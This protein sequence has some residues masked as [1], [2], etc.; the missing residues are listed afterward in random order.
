[1]KTV[2]EEKTNV[3]VFETQL[4]DS[5][6]TTRRGEMSKSAERMITA[7]LLVFF[8]VVLGLTAYLFMTRLFL[9]VEILLVI[10]VIS[11]L[12]ALAILIL[13]FSGLYK[14]VRISNPA[15]IQATDIAAVFGLIGIFSCLAP[16]VYGVFSIPDFMI[17]LQNFM[18]NQQETAG[19]MLKILQSLDKRI[20]SSA[21]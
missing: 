8:L 20:P 6:K 18:S 1:M 4:L 7:A 9:V 17:Q 14:V 16:T 2:I 12:V 19:K 10:G 3:S 21:P 5:K 15:N 11:F 13:K